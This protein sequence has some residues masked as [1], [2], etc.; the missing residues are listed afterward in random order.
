MEK[1][2]LNKLELCVTDAF[3]QLKETLSTGSQ[4]VAYS[5]LLSNVTFIPY[6]QAGPT[7]GNI[8]AGTG[9]IN[10]SGL[11]TNINQLTSS[12][13]IDWNSY[14]LNSSEIVNYIQPGSSS[15]ALNRILGGSA[16]QIHGQINAN[17]QVVLVN[18]KEHTGSSLTCHILPEF[19]NLDK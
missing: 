9:A 17:G 14:N 7:G 15:I 18:P 19:D 13:A 10:H 6:V 4:V 12:L 16:S 5:L 2:S 1:V 3:N 8:V 11:T